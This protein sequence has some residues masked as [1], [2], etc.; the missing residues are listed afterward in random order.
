[1]GRSDLEI[2]LIALKLLQTALKAGLT[3]GQATKILRRKPAPKY[4][5]ERYKIYIFK[6][7][8]A[9]LAAQKKTKVR[10]PRSM[11]SLSQAFR[12]LAHNKKFKSLIE[13]RGAGKMN[14][15]KFIRHLEYVWR[16]IPVA[17]KVINILKKKPPQGIFAALPKNQYLIM[18]AEKIRI[19]FEDKQKNRRKKKDNY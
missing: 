15:D 1:M 19:E 17:D 2:D 4:F 18:L 3:P 9:T 11:F 5:D 8:A 6:K 14:K 16:E 10:G 13:K 12:D 7:V